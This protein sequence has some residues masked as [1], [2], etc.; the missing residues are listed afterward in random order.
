MDSLGVESLG[1]PLD[2]EGIT[3]KG[4]NCHQSFRYGSVG[5]LDQ[6]Q[7]VIINLKGYATSGGQIEKPVTI[8]TRLM[9][10][11]CGKKSRSSFT[12]CPACGTRLE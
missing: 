4:S 6:S 2:D 7:V 9:C 12:F 1:N 8:K 11:S 3:V 10:S 5:E